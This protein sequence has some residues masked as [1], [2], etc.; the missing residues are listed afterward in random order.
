MALFCFIFQNYATSLGSKLGVAGRG[1]KI[2][3]QD[4]FSF[5]AVHRFVFDDSTVT[6][7]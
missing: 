1:I 7:S 6:I 3:F 4:Y 5:F 2:V